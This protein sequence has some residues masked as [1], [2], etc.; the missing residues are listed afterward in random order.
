MICLWET[1]IRQSGKGEAEAYLVSMVEKGV[2][3]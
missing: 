1:Q 2:G 3:K